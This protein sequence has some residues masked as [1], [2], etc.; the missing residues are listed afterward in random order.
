M[1]IVAEEMSRIAHTIG[2][3]VRHLRHDGTVGGSRGGLGGIKVDTPSHLA[4][5][6]DQQQVILTG[7]CILDITILINTWIITAIHQITVWIMC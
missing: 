6:C 2:S 1:G 4:K 5:V 3:V 7:L